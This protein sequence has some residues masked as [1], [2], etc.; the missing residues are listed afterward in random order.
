MI[1]LLAGL[2]AL[3]TPS[4]AQVPDLEFSA[5]AGP[6]FPVG[7]LGKLTGTGFG[8]GMGIAYPLSRRVLL[9]TDV[10]AFSRPGASSRPP[11]APWGSSSGSTR[12]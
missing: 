9:R 7:D 2:L 4:E 1:A 12:R 3:P 8:V 11:G 5:W 6:A 10:Q